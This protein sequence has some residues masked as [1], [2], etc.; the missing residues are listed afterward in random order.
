[1]NFKEELQ[2]ISKY[3]RQTENTIQ[4]I[5]DKARKSAERGSYY[6]IDAYQLEAK[7][8]CHLTLQCNRKPVKV[9]DIQMTGKDKFIYDFFKQ[10]GFEITFDSVDL[11][12]YPSFGEE[13]YK[14]AFFMHLSWSTSIDK[15]G[16]EC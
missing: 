11:N 13:G 8:N 6:L 12:P 15:K 10:E 2:A 3:K 4:D 9:D 16:G 5:K 7:N 1:M 14:A